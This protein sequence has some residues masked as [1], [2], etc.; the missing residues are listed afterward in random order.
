[1]KS[2]LKSLLLLLAICASYPVVGLMSSAHAG[3]PGAAAPSSLDLSGLGEEEQLALR[4]KLV[5]LKKTQSASGM[6]IP[7]VDKLSEWASLGQQF[8]AGLAQ[9][10]K[11]L[12]VTANEFVN[13]PVG[14]TVAAIIVWK[15]MGS[16]ILHIVG[17]AIFFVVAM[18][19]WWT[20]WHRIC[21]IKSTKHV[22]GRHFF[23][24]LQ[25]KEVTYFGSGEVDSERVTLSIFAFIITAATLFIIFSY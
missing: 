6:S 23:W 18:T 3:T 11:E 5:E 4:Q 13:T 17:G 20:A 12:G 10:A 8:G 16:A 2:F 15:L 14:R 24:L 22:A 1:M 9:T 21:V 7:S 25:N 19:I